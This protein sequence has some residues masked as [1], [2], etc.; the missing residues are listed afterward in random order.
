MD[1]LRGVVLGPKCPSCGKMASS[2]TD[3][4][5]LE[6]YVR[7]RHVCKVCGGTFSTVEITVTMSQNPERMRQIVSEI[8]AMFTGRQQT[9]PE[10]QKENIC[11][12]GQKSVSW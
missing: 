1:K 4:R 9:A 3:S 7:R 11:Q 10:S 2:V 5:G 12:G 6:G 8:E